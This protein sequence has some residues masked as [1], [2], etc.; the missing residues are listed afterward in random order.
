MLNL[1]FMII[2]KLFQFLFDITNKHENFHCA[3]KK[4]LGYLEIFDLLKLEMLE[5][6]AHAVEKN[7]S[8]KV[9]K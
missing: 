6:V 4:Y 2:S 8:K 9:R 5:K 1:L 7:E 3:N